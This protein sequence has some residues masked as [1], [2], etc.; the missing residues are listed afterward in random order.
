[1]ETT[2]SLAV[3]ALCLFTLVTGLGLVL[4]A[5]FNTYGDKLSI[6]D[7]SILGL[8]GCTLMAGSLWLVVSSTTHYERPLQEIIMISMAVGC[9]LG[10]LIY[11]A[12]VVKGLLPD[13]H[14]AYEDEA[15]YNSFS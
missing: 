8:I 9:S 3:E 2:L 13:H 1:L 11:L 10:A 14:V 12:S 15:P 5:L 4:M 7:E 6:F